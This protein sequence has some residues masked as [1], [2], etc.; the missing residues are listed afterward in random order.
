[1]I[2]YLIVATCV[3]YYSYKDFK[4]A[5]NAVVKHLLAVPLCIATGLLWPVW[6][7]GWIVGI[8]GWVYKLGRETVKK[9]E[10]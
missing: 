10:V 8:V 4:K 6:A 2:F 9:D 3:A 7:F 5:D 1:M